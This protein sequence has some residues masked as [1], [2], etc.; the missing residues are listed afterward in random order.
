[1]GTA[2][3]RQCMQ[4]RGDKAWVYLGLGAVGWL[5]SSWQLSPEALARQGDSICGMAGRCCR[6]CPTSG[7]LAP[8]C[9]PGMSSLATASVLPPAALPALPFTYSRSRSSQNPRGGQLCCA[10]Q[11]LQRDDYSSAVAHLCP[12]LGLV[13]G[14]QLRSC[15]EVTGQ[16]EEEGSTGG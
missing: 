3:K 14:L 2:G 1:M 13:V 6:R 16:K 12:L 7:G 11:H 15:R 10:M 4:G 5:G 8:L 9:L